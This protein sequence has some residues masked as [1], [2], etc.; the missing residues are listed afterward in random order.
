MASV[1]LYWGQSQSRFER[2]E[3]SSLRVL[4]EEVSVEYESVC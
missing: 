2:N 3:L 4:K 1:G